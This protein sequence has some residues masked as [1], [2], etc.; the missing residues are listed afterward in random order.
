MK[1]D[2]PPPPPHLSADAAAWW[3]KILDEWVLDHPSTL[4]LTTALEAFDRMK[5]AQEVIE[6]HGA[7]VADRFGQLRCNPATLVE[8]DS[9]SAMLN[10]LKQLHFDVEP[11]HETPGR[12]AGS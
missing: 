1:K 3:A 12:P 4:I 5:A 11:L 10:A 7:V 2:T 6:E 9:R 8:R